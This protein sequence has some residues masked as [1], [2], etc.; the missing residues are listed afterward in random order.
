MRCGKKEEPSYGKNRSENVL[1]NVLVGL[2]FPKL[3]LQPI[4]SVA[5]SLPKP[6]SFPSSSLRGGHL[7]PGQTDR[8]KHRQTIR[9][10]SFIGINVHPPT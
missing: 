5:H 4:P 8:Q 6:A 3:P 2:F 10:A 9:Q 7:C 1:C